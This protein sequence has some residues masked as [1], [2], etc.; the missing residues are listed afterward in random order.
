MAIVSSKADKQKSVP[1]SNMTF[2][3]ILPAEYIGKT[4]VAVVALGVKYY[5]LKESA[6][7]AIYL[8]KRY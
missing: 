2:V 3:A 6:I 4:H 7:G 8:P 5:L 1:Q